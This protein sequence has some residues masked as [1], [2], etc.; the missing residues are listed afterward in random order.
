MVKLILA[1]GGGAEDSK[2]LDKLFV[3]LI[4]KG[5]KMLYIPVARKKDYKECYNWIKS[6]FFP[7]GFDDI[8]MWT[9]LSNKRYE[10]LKGIGAIYVGGGNTFRLLSELRSTKFDEILMKFIRS[11]RIVYGGSAGAIVLGKN[12][13]TS[14]DENVAKI[15]NFSGFGII[16]NCSVW[17]H[18]NKNQDSKILRYIK[19]FGFPV[20]AIPNRSGIFLDEEKVEIIGSKQ[21]YLFKGHKKYKYK[22]NSYL[23]I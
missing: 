4:P 19:K 14:S 5:K 22:P 10:D 15:K 9:D 2:Q 1:G 11:D 8:I 12:I 6:V 20:I 7:L 16:K 17:C 21:V 18:Y 13:L 23:K 3:S